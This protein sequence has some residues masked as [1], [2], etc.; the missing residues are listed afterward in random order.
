MRIRSPLRCEETYLTE[1]FFDMEKMKELHAQ[2]AKCVEYIDGL[3]GK[4]VERAPEN[5]YFIVTADHGELFGEVGMSQVD[6]GGKGTWEV[7][8]SMSPT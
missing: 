6:L 3:F 8:I 4:L 2:Q 1:E 5:T 7:T